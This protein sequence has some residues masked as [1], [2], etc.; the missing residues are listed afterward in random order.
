MK[1]TLILILTCIFIVGA[2]IINIFIFLSLRGQL[3]D[4]QF[5][6]NHLQTKLDRLEEL[7]DYETALYQLLPSLGWAELRAANEQIRQQKYKS[8]ESIEMPLLT[9][10]ERKK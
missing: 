5:E 1:N 9:E 7:G 8:Y 2:L 6:C 3:S 4:C 10:E